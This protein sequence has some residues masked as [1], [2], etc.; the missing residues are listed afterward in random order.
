MF[1]VCKIDIGP[2]VAVEP[3]R[4]GA[5]VNCA[6]M[7]SASLRNTGTV[8][9]TC[10][11]CGTASSFEYKDS[12]A[13][14]GF[15][16]QDA[17]IRVG[18]RDYIRIIYQLVRCAY[19]GRGA[20]AT[21]AANRSILGGALLA[22]DPKTTTR[23]PLPASVPEGIELEFRE[24]ELCMSIEAHRGASALFRSA[25]E[26]ALTDSGYDDSVGKLFKKI[27]AA[28]K[29]GVITDARRKKAH[30]EVRVL[31]NDVVHEEWRDISLEDVRSAHHY[32]QRVL[33]DLYDDRPSVEAILKANGRRK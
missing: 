23:A 13:E 1:R 18:G 3:G 10:P 24:A 11:T 20:L 21:I 30:D 12:E 28:A 5:L 14:F 4:I 26:K 33:E 29:D 32:T 6:C 9:A 8:A 2:A 19:C 31:G 25:L 17:G 27:E 22:F 7:A 16:A 15:I